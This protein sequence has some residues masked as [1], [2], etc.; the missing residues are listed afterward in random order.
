MYRRNTPGFRQKMSSHSVQPFGR[1]KA[2]YIYIYESLEDILFCLSVCLFVCLCPIKVK[3]VE[4]IERK[5][6][7]IKS[8][9]FLKI[10]LQCKQRK[11]VHI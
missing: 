10:V 1:I 5:K 4:P 6:I 8:A 7:I 3:T 2:I 11:S 9:N